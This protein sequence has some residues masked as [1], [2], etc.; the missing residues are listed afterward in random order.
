MKLRLVATAIAVAS[1]G[2]SSV[3]NS[4]EIVLSPVEPA[5]LSV[6]QFGLPRRLPL[7]GSSKEVDPS[8]TSSPPSGDRNATGTQS[9]SNFSGQYTDYADAF[10]G[11]S[12]KIPTEFNLQGKGA[13]T[14]W[15]GP[16]LV[17]TKANGEDF[18]GGGLISVNTVEWPAG[19]PGVAC[20]ATVTQYRND[21][22]YPND[23]ISSKQVKFGTIPATVVY[24]EESIYQRGTRD[25]KNADDH[26]RLH[27]QVC[28]NGRIYNGIL[29][30]YYG[31][32]QR[33]D[34]DLQSLFETVRQSF[35]LV[36]ADNAPLGG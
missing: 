7:P 36:P 22:Y 23:K 21:R 33:P 12:L 20:N 18:T 35:E 29:S 9:F 16:L 11:F 5:S 6:A 17:G 4:T 34:L 27:F 14:S 2:T 28:G 15:G 1:F 26:H 3:A 24:F 13:T 19:N 32:F 10:N 25:E 8:S 31:F 30:Y